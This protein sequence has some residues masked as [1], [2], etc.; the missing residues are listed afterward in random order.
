MESATA[1]EEL[2]AIR[3]LMAESQTYLCGTWPHQLAWGILG[4]VG[5]VATWWTGRGEAFPAVAWIWGTILALG[6]TFSIVVGRRAGRGA[7]VHNVAARAFA[8]IWVALGVTLSLLG[9]VTI[10]TGAVDPGGLPG[11]LAIVLGAGYCASGVLT[12]LRWLVGV[13]VLWWSGGVGLL[14]LAGPEALLGL[15]VMALLFEV[16]PALALRRREGSRDTGR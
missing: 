15:A 12:G 11:V 9:M 6:W 4:A 7:P 16:G 10:P 5:L 3:G 8:G 13:A 1:R 2:A 14:L